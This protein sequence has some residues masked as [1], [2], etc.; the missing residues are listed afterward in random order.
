MPEQKIDS[1]LR[2][3]WRRA[4][5]GLCWGIFGIGGLLLTMTWFPYL[6]LTEKNDRRR[7]QRARRAIAW[8]FRCFIRLNALLG[9][10]RYDASDIRSLRNVKGAIIVANHPTILDYVLIASQLPEMDCLVKAELMHN[11]FLK[12]VVKAADYMLNDA[13]ETLLEECA[14]RLA[15]GDNILIFPEGTRTVPGEPLK[16]KRGV[17]HIAL[18]LH[19]PIEVVHIDSPS[20]WLSKKSHWWEIPRE[21]PSITVTRRECVNPDDFLKEGEDGY[22]LASRRLTR[23]LTQRLT[24]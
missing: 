17:A 20:G 16:L 10:G 18:R 15:A 7:V 22:A 1:G 3:Q 12:G 19:A 14:R 4:M 5:T 24:A 9:V 23:E 8:S 6:N 2:F 13:S 11:F 21:F